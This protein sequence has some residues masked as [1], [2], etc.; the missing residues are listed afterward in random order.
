VLTS[1]HAVGWFCRLCWLQN[2]TLERRLFY[3]PSFKIYG[4]VA[5]FYDYGPPGCA[6]KQ[7]LTQVR[8]RG[9]AG[10]SSCYTAGLGSRNTQQLVARSGDTCRAGAAGVQDCLCSGSAASGSGSGRGRAVAVPRWSLGCVQQGQ[11][12]GQSSLAGRVAMTVAGSS[13]H[14]CSRGNAAETARLETTR[15]RISSRP[16]AQHCSTISD[17]GL[18]LKRD[19]GCS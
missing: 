15:C 7:N 4:S 10:S 6:I 18:S 19:A 14:H 11:E 17:A 16:T 5:G 13:Q 8:S 2:N 12:Q 1:G 3:I 9:M